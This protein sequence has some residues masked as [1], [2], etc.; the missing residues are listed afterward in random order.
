MVKG[1][2]TD[3]IKWLDKDYVIKDY[4]FKRAM[5]VAQNKV[6]KIYSDDIDA[7]LFF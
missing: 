1:K 2:I 7:V 6:S 4:C 5:K 3:K